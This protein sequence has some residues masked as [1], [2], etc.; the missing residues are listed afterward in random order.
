M[1]GRRVLSRAVAS[2]CAELYIFSY[3]YGGYEYPQC[4]CGGIHFEFYGNRTAGG[5]YLL[6]KY[7]VFGGTGAVGA[8]LVDDSDSGPVSGGDPGVSYEP[9]ESSA[10]ACEQEAQQSVENKISLFCL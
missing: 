10:K 9:G 1:H 7:A 6:G 8:C 3:V 4:D 2:S 5:G